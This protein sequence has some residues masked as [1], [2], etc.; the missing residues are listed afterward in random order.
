MTK[1]LL[2][3][4]LA[5]AAGASWAQAEPY[6]AGL[7]SDRRPDN[8][9]RL[10]QFSMTDAQVAHGLRGVE[11]TLPGNVRDIASA[12]AWWTPLNHEG[13]PTPYDL[14]HMHSGAAAADL[15]TSTT[16]AANAGAH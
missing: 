7:H 3:L 2:S 16:P 5:L 14:R 10:T 4:A 9:P 6:V 12:G 1:T 13:M 15:S 8:A 11:G